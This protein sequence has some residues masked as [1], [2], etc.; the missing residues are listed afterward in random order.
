MLIMLN[1]AEIPVSKNVR[2]DFLKLFNRVKSV[3]LKKS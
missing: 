3:S 2:E 1:D